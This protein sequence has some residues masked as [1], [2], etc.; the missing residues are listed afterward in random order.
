MRLVAGGST[1]GFCRRAA[2][3]FTRAAFL[4]GL[5]RCGFR[6]RSRLVLRSLARSLFG[7]GLVLRALALRLV[8]RSS[9]FYISPSVTG[10]VTVLLFR[11]EK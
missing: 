1:L 8:L 6:R 11:G 9:H 7:C 3:G 2:A 5:V 4:S 10:C